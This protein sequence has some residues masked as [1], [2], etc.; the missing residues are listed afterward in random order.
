MTYQ[1]ALLNFWNAL[2]L[3]AL[4]QVKVRRSCFHSFKTENKNKIARIANFIYILTHA[5]LREMFIPLL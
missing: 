3:C 2:P 4:C 5:V 1:Y